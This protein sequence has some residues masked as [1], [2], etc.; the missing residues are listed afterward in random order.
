MN[1]S[2]IFFNMPTWKKWENNRTTSHTN[3][4]TAC[5]SSQ[6]PE[7]PLCSQ[8]LLRQGDKSLIQDVWK[9][10]LAITTAEKNFHLL[11]ASSQGQL[12]SR[13]SVSL[14]SHGVSSTSPSLMGP[15]V[16][17]QL[18]FHPSQTPDILPLCRL[19][20]VSLLRISYLSSSVTHS[21]PSPPE[22]P[23]S[24]SFLKD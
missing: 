2:I 7:V 9:P 5:I 23:F 22:R 13:S 21:S 24:K 6:H 19:S 15:Q 12:L 17:G 3:I 18:S 10:C 4:T 14:N 8:R 16:P 20:T 11:Q 1:R